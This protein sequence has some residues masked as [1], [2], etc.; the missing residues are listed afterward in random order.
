MDSRSNDV[1]GRG[2]LWTTDHV[3]EEEQPQLG[4]WNVKGKSSGQC[5]T[6]VAVHGDDKQHTE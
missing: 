1:T 6:V 2:Q 5:S 4:F 3:C